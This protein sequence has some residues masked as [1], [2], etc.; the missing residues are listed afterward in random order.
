MTIYTCPQGGIA[1]RDLSITQRVFEGVQTR[2]DAPVLID[3]ATGREMT[4]AAFLA[5]VKALAGGLT[6]RGFGKGA[7]VA[8]MMPNI[9]EFCVAFHAV[10]WAGGTVTTVNP[11][12]TARELGH[13]LMASAA[14]LFI[15]V[16]E[17][18][19]VAREGMEDTGVR[20]LA[21]V[22]EAEG[23]M[24]LAALSGAPLE[25]QVPVDLDDHIL[26]LPFSSGT[27][28]LPKGVMLTHRNLVANVEQI[29]LHRP[30]A[31]GEWTV[32]F[33]PFF[34]IY[35]LT[36]LANFYLAS[37]GGVVTMPRFD[38]PL[39]LKLCQ[40][41]RVPQVFVVPPVVLAMAKHPLVDQFD[42]SA[43]RYLFSGAAPLGASLAEAAAARLGVAC[44][45]GYGM[46][47][48][49]P[50]SH[51]SR[52]GEGRPGASG[53]P[54]PGTECRIVDPATMTDVPRGGE[55]ELWVR[56]PQV[57]KGYLNN[58]TATAETLLPGGWLRTGDIG[59][60]D[61]DG[62][63]CIRDRLKELIKTK[64]F[65]VAPAELEAVLVAH[66]DIA[67]AAVVGEPDEDA[68][69]VPVAYLVA[70][71]DR[72]LTPEEIEAWFEGKLAHFK[73]VRRIRYI[74]AIPKSASG[75]ILRRLLRDRPAAA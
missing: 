15:T 51:C 25:A 73:R 26:V 64:G 69:E 60:F 4:G 41:H 18:A 45:Q 29:S 39:F 37:G 22:G 56:G 68:G 14:T 38:L 7:T 8:L 27:T 3:G 17:L 10:A 47:E 30:C 35:G 33:L 74:E 43:L 53:T 71:G 19:A 24:P 5:A 44:E 28:G 12:Y 9:P 34:H 48:M 59:A 11:A 40:D 46:T 67:D 6:E 52:K 1:L 23:A 58:P 62:H 42:L 20:A 16:P 75:K 57:M 70:R 49:S 2:A 72:R 61:A 21:V 55:G 50:V 36:V 65:Q 54:I 63:L 13:Q 32:G 66:P 31:P